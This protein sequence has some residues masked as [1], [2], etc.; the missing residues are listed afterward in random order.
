LSYYNNARKSRK[1]VHKAMSKRELGTLGGGSAE[2]DG[3]RPKRRKDGAGAASPPAAQTSISAHA[4]AP[5]N[6]ALA[7]E[8]KAKG[9]TFWQTVRT[10]V[11]KE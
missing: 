1:Y 10:A 6:P 7:V 8:L 9:Q 11:N 4:A 5:I 2:L 3:T